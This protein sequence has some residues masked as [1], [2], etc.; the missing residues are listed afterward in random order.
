MGVGDGMGVAVAVGIG[1]LV[2]GMGEGVL[3]GVE[4]GGGKTAVQ[5]VSSTR[6]MQTVKRKIVEAGCW[7]IGAILPSESVLI[8]KIGNYHPAG[9]RNSTVGRLFQLG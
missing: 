5:A 1:V 2:A 4:V 6:I 9:L 3:V 7:R 8:T